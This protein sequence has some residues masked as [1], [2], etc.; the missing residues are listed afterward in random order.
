MKGSWKEVSVDE[1]RFVWMTATNWWSTFSV[2]SVLFIDFE[3]VQFSSQKPKLRQFLSH[4]HPK[5]LQWSPAETSKE[6]ASIIVLTGD[7]DV[8]DDCKL[9]DLYEKA[10]HI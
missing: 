7:L 10:R 4:P 6:M 8:E 9:A 1:D 5:Y 3:L 2:I